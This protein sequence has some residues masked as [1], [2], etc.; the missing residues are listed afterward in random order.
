MTRELGSGAPDSDTGEICFPT[1]QGLSD[2]SGIVL[3]F[4]YSL[5]GLLRWLRTLYD[6][7]NIHKMHLSN[8]MFRILVS[9][10][11]HSFVHQAAHILPRYLCMLH[12]AV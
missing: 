9:P 3:L 7:I 1:L 5:Q 10:L 4:R 11:I 12:W 6:Q 8:S 2:S